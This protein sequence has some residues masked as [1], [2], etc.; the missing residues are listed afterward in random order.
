MKNSDEFNFCVGRMFSELHRAFPVRLD[1]TIPDDEWDKPVELGGSFGYVH[2]ETIRWLSEEGYIRYEAVGPVRKTKMFS[3]CSL[4]EKGLAC[5]N[6][7]PRSLKGGGTPRALA[8][9]Y[10]KP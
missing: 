1:W 7:M 5:L 10:P 2:A 8:I 6:A 9:C 4:T 3:K